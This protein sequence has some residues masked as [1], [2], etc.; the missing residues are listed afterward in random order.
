MF[1]NFI[2]NTHE[3]SLICLDKAFVSVDD[4]VAPASLLS[5][6]SRTKNSWKCCTLGRLHCGQ[7]EDLKDC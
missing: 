7:A 3:T 2:K 6:F 1:H 4:S 5:S